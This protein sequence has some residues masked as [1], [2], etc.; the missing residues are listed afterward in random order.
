MWIAKTVN[1]KF[2]N[3]ARAFLLSD[4]QQNGVPWPAYIWHWHSI[5]FNFFLTALSKHNIGWQIWQKLF[6]L[7]LKMRPF[8]TTSYVLYCIVLS[9]FELVCWP[10]SRLNNPQNLSSTKIFL[11]I[12]K[13]EAIK[14]QSDLRAFK[15]SKFP[16]KSVTTILAFSRFS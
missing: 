15:R 12:W 16:P 5:C 8:L 11:V 4:C 14:W 1:S 7:C 6:F 2:T 10:L 9:S 3:I 13:N